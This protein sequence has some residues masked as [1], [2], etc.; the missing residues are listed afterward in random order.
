VLGARI[1]VLLKEI[2][3]L[4]LFPLFTKTEGE[5]LGEATRLEVKYGIALITYML[6]VARGSHNNT[7]SLE[8]R[9]NK[10][11][12]LLVEFWWW[13]HRKAEYVMRQDFD[14]KRSWARIPGKL[15]S[16]IAGF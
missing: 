16:V 2:S 10:T 11:A 9:T 15:L 1:V 3:E 7:I 5:A 12:I 8:S 13:L 4:S 6:E 14:R